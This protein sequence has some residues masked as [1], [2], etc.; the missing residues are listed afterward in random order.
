MKKY[1]LIL[2]DIYEA[3]PLTENFT[4]LIVAIDNAIESNDI[5]ELE[6]MGGEYLNNGGLAYKILSAGFT[7]DGLMWSN[8]AHNQYNQVRSIDSLIKDINLN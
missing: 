2:G 1:I 4:T 5:N 8:L 3:D 7:H 6:L